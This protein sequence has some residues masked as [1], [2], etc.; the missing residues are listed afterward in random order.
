M[1]TWPKT[2]SDATDYIERAVITDDGVRL[3]VRDYC[4]DGIANHTVV[5]L[6]G[7][8]LSQEVW[9]SQIEALQQRW[10]DNIRVITYD[11]R[12]HGRSGGAL[13]N[14]YRVDQLG[15]DLAAVLAA[16]DVTGPLTLAGHSMG[17]MTALAYLGRP[18]HGR[19]V[20]PQ[21]LVLIA[22]AAGKL[23]ERGIGRLL[24]TP[25]TG[26]L[27]EL[28]R[29]MPRRGTDRAI[30]TL[31]RPLR[32]ALSSYAERDERNALAAVA[33]KAV[34]TTSLSTL[35]GFFLGLKRYDEYRTLASI[36]AKTVVLSGGAD[37]LTPPSHAR[38]IAASVPGAVHL[39]HPTAGHMLLQDAPEF[40][41]AAINRAMSADRRSG[42]GSHLAVVAS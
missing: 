15:A 3:A 12:G 37:Q 38:D 39:Q 27:F 42:R 28:V 20:E 32:N 16:L 17:G 31:I 6:H 21:G 7:L 13:M 19:P 24:A 35:A 26:A 4:A 9:E 14:T 40:V 33:Q 1:L 41:T 36:T 2:P 29:R 18:A 11:H 5:L 8:S 30:Q 34:G 23:S 25:A 10:G 22:S